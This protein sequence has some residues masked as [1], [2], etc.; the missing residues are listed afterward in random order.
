MAGTAAVGAAERWRVRRATESAEPKLG[1]ELIVEDE[2]EADC[3]IIAVSPVCA[4]AV[5]WCVVLCSI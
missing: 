1:A 3:S 2:V 4:A 5:L